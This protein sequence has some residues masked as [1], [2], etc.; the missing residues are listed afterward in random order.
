M[1]A[2]EERIILRRETHL[3]QLVDELQEDRVRRVVEPLLSGDTREF[4]AR[5]LEYARDLGPDR[6][7]QSAAHRQSGVR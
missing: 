7:G 1:T 5:D 6:A 3:D 4:S 2:A